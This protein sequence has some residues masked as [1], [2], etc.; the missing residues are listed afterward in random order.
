MKE[1]SK[2]RIYEISGYQSGA[3][4]DSRFLQGDVIFQKDL[5]NR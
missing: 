4:A 1:K 2:D 3:D 5:L